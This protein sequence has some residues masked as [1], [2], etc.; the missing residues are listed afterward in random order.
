LINCKTRGYRQGVSRDIALINC[1]TW[2]NIED[3]TAHRYSIKHMV[4]F[5]VVYTDIQKYV[6]VYACIN[7]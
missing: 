4:A 3:F 5:A 7:F 1:Y 2:Y 6:K